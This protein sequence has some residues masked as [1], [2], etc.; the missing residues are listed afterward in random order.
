MIRPA[1]EA[2]MET[3]VRQAD[4]VLLLQSGERS[5]KRFGKGRRQR[6]G[7]GA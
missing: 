7:L 2:L 5:A 4:R 3:I 1:A 6:F